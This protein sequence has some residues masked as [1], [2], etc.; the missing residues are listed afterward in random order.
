MEQTITVERSIW[1]ETTID[2]AWR[3][4]TEPGQLDQWYAKYYRWD[5]PA[6][7]VGTTVKFYDKDPKTEVE[8]DM[9]LATIEVV[10]PPREFTLRWQPQPE[11]PMVSLVTSFLLAEEDG[12]TR[13]TISEG[14]YENVPADERQTWLDQTGSGYGMSM[15]NLKAHLEGKAIPH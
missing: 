1:I 15:E 8:M 11:Y 4:V 6:L 12:G 3:A 7:E 10:N 5:I 14:G 13:V 2:R 9:Q